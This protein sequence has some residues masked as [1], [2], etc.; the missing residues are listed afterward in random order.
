[1]NN[2]I[3]VI[4]LIAVLVLGWMT[5]QTREQL[6]QSERQIAVLQESITVT[7]QELVQVNGKLEE[8]NKTSVKGLVKEANNAI[9]DGW[10]ALV[11]SVE[12]EVRKARESMEDNA[13]EPEN[14]SPSVQQTPTLESPDGTD[15]T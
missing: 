3:S 6:L 8:L 4:L 13:G 15:R 10:E 9:L 11:N 12:N 7:Q 1:M 14:A 5:Y 2:L